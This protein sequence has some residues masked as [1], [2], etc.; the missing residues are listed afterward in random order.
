[1][2]RF[3]SPSFYA[4]QQANADDA[5][6]ISQEN[7]H[8]ATSHCSLVTIA[9]ARTIAENR[10]CVNKKFSFHPK[11]GRMRFMRLTTLPSGRATN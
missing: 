9:S 11:F 1:M 8:T 4:R 5:G 7:S 3:G 10:L 6:D 2:A